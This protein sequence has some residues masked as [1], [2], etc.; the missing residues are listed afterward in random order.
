LT[1]TSVEKSISTAQPPDDQDCEHSA[2][3]LWEQVEDRL[4]SDIRSGIY[5]PGDKLPPERELMETFGVGRPS[6]REALF[7]LERRGLVRLRKG[8]R[9]E[10]TNQSPK[11]ILTALSVIADGLL[12]TEEGVAQ[13]NNARKLFEISL[14]RYASENATL[15]QLRAIETTLKQS[16]AAIGDQ[17][18]FKQLDIRF[19]R[20]LAEIPENPVLIALHDALV[21]WVMYRRSTPPEMLAQRHRSA[22]DGHIAVANAIRRRDPDA[23]QAAMQG[24][25]E[26]A[27]SESKRFVAQSTIR[28]QS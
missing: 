27:L 18:A 21:E 2:G 8:G 14:A 10:V 6:I 20:Q 9:P 5:R 24:H 15:S 25:L 22:L 4:V 28:P 11:A 19:H 17:A 3:R 16:E 23:A 26:N 1:K 7:S 13:F 12:A